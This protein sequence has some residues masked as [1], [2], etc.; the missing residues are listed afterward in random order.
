MQCI[1]LTQE[2]LHQEKFQQ[3]IF[4]G[5]GRKFWGNC[6]KFAEIALAECAAK[7]QKAHLAG[8]RIRKTRVLAEP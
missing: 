4:S 5:I 6:A 2:C 8:I 7:W 3:G 1:L